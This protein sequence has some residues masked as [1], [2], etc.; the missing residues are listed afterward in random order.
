MDRRAADRRVPGRAR[1]LSREPDRPCPRP[2]SRTCCA[3][4]RRRSSAR[5]S[6]VTGTS[7]TAE[8]ATQEALIAAAAQWPAEGLPDHPRG[9][10]I[11]VA[12][13][14][15]TDLLRADQARQR[16][17]DTVARWVLP[18]H[19]LAPAGRPAA[20][21]PRRH[22]DPAVH[23]LSSRADPGL[24]DRADAPRGRRPDHRG[25]RPGVPGPRGDH[26]PADQPGQAADQGQ[27]GAVPDA[28]RRRTRRTARGGAARALP[29]LHRGLR[30]HVRA[31]PAPHRAG[32][33]G[34]QAGPSRAPAAPRGR[35]GDRAACAHAADRRPAAG[36]HRPGRRADPHGR[37]GPEPVERR[38]DRRGRGPWSPPPWPAAR[39]ARTSCRR[40]S[41]RSTTRRRPPMRPTGRRSWPCTSCSCGCPTTRS[42]G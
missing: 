2:R 38:P 28:R 42:C 29:D 33:R 23:V 11:T 13:R 4:W 27:R 16:R 7:S 15:L 6:G 34:D 25:D 24:A 30:Q 17:E 9:W 1:C 12:S 31:E 5:W 37:T 22:A 40:P 10:L 19:W 36:P 26:D 21:G 8:D 32:R 41:P 39:P 35:R 3:S 18:D 20:R 14:R